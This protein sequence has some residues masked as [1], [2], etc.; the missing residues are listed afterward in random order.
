M[1]VLILSYVAICTLVYLAY[2]LTHN[3]FKDSDLNYKN[4]DSEYKIIVIITSPI[5]GPIVITGLIF[6]SIIAFILP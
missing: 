4:N 3:N 2:M 6:L 5:A 1:I